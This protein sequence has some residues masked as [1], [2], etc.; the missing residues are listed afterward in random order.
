[1]SLRKFS[2]GLKRK[3]KRRF[4]GGRHELERTVAD[5]DGGRVG[6]TLSLPQPR[7]HAIAKDEYNRPVSWNDA[8]ADGGQ[9]DSADPTPYSGDPGFVPISEGQHDSEVAIEGRETSE[10]GSYPGLDVDH[11]VEG[12]PS[13]GGDVDQ[14]DPSTHSISRGG[15]SEST[16]M[17]HYLTHCL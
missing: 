15:E 12:A 6:S 5:V 9:V 3:L 16:Q 11:V 10:R 2:S 17:T 8:C 4:G 14:L 1:M 13:Q 7:P